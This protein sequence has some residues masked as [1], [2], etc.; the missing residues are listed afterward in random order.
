MV[1]VNCCPG[2]HLFL[3]VNNGLEGKVDRISDL[4]CM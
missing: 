1:L 4:L 3:L 2:I